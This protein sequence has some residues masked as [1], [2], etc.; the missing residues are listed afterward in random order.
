MAPGSSGNTSRSGR[1]STTGPALL[2]HDYL[3]YLTPQADKARDF[4]AEKRTTIR[5]AR[6]RGL[7]NCSTQARGASWRV[8]VTEQVKANTAPHSSSTKLDSKITRQI[9]KHDTKNDP[10]R[11]K[12]KTQPEFELHVNSTRAKRKTQNKE[13][14]KISEQAYRK[15]EGNALRYT[16]VQVELRPCSPVVHFVTPKVTAAKP[17]D[18]Q[19]Q[20]LR[21]VQQAR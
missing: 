1:R 7:R 14:I 12:Q 11:K 19:H 9:V 13:V 21:C 4:V 6:P 2:Q 10:Q 17:L 16:V 20:N 8:A 5:A 3:N 18:V 15:K